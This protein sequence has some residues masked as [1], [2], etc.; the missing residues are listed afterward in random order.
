MTI[1]E[2][3]KQYWGY[4]S[5][6]PMQE[7]I[8]R[9]VLEGHDTLG[10][11]PTGGGKSIT[12]QVPALAL[13][14]LCVVITPLISLMKDQA[15]HLTERGIKAAYLHM[16]LTH[17]EVVETYDRICRE[18]YSF[19][20]V[21]PERL[22]GT[23]FQSQLYYMDVRMV[24]VDEAHCISQWGYD[25]RPA[26]LKIAELRS[27]LRH[28]EV[29]FM[30]LTATATRHT[31]DDIAAKLHFRPGYQVF[32]ASFV[33]PN[34][35]Y[36]VRYTS[37]KLGTTVDLM[38]SVECGI[39]YVRSRNNTESIAKALLDA[40][41]KAD[42]YHAGLP[43]SVRQHKQDE[44]IRGEK[45]VMVAT[46]AF[47]MGIDKPNVR[48]VVHLGLDPSP[49]EYF[50]E[51]GRAGRDLQPADAILLADPYEAK[52]LLGH[53]TKEFP[54]R[55][56]IRYVYERLGS[57]FQVAIGA[58]EY[59]TFTFNEFQFCKNFHL[60]PTDTFYALRILEQ[61]GYIALRDSSD[62]FSALRM[63]VSRDYLYR[64]LHLSKEADLTLNALLRIYTG[65]FADFV[66]IQ[67]EKIATHTYLD[68]EQIYQALLELKRKG[69]IDYRPRRRQ[70][71]ITY[72]TPRLDVSELRI[73]S[74]IYEDRRERMMGRTLAMVSYLENA[75]ECRL[76]QLLRY[77][78]EEIKEDCGRCDVCLRKA[79]TLPQGEANHTNPE[80]IDSIHQSINELIAAEPGLSDEEICDHIAQHK[81]TDVSEVLRMM[82]EVGERK[83]N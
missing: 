38:R 16:G 61:A 51:A 21:S 28:K 2:I 47:G 13:G 26:Y 27:M 70:P 42:F 1:H 10:L 30:A 36:S 8:I 69:I 52:K 12:F 83:V 4:D 48:L 19:L 66:N 57:L 63:T 7:D 33:R 24:V 79:H 9:S 55:E 20:Y 54:E 64:P 67:E 14:G 22:A 46:N 29:P 65:V 35:T 3:L 73:P 81:R 78:G 37:D 53:V 6:R 15:D 44:W 23:L 58:G 62:S 49:E 50:Q 68:S 34:L 31:I 5:F 71:G 17:D 56:F 43:T 18:H 82:N 76:R 59:A 45:T 41:V 77:F 72:L 39:V 11:L 74:S 75:D 60:P 80:L 40:G 32:R 25:F